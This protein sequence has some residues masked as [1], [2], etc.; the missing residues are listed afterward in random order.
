MD[1]LQWGRMAAAPAAAIARWQPHAV[2]AENA[3]PPRRDSI[4]LVKL[5]SPADTANTVSQRKQ[6]GSTINLL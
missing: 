1:A 2:A 5:D 3:K 4:A 6:K